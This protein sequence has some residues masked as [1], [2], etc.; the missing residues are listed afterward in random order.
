MWYRIFCRS[1]QTQP[2]AGLAAHLQAL[3]L[4]TQTHVRGDDLGWTSAELRLGPGSP[5]YL[6]RFLVKEDELR[7][8]L[9]NWAAWLETAT[10]SEHSPALMERVIQT[11]QLI[12]LRKPIDHPDEIALETLCLACCQFIATE[13]EGIYQIDDDGWYAADGTLLVKEY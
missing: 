3:G 8:D 4:Q 11:Q 10:W 12:T 5:V 6:E 1:G 7:G 9:N 2:I 13:C